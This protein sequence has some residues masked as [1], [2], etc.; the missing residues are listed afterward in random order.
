MVLTAG[1]LPL[2]GVVE[3]SNACQTTNNSF[4]EGIEI[5]VVVF[6][7]LLFILLLCTKILCFLLHASFFFAIGRGG[8]GDGGNQ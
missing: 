3:R 4:R 2:I 1:G 8:W 7:L 6:I 5:L